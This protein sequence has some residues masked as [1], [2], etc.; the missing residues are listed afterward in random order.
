MVGQKL[1]PWYTDGVPSV[2]NHIVYSDCRPNQ[3]GLGKTCNM[4][5]VSNDTP[6]KL[7]VQT[8]KMYAPFGAK[9]WEAKEPNKLPKWDLVLNFKGNSIMMSTFT[10]LIKAIDESN[11]THAF[12][13]QESFFS[14]KGKS[15]DIIADRYSSLYNSKDSKYDP[16]LNTKLDVRN[17]QFNGQIYDANENIQTI[18]YVTAQSYVQALIEFGSLWVVD[19]R[20]GMTI[21]SIQL[22]VHKQDQIDKLSIVPMDTD[23][24]I[25][26]HFQNDQ[27]SEEEIDESE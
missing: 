1:V 27:L 23:E 4:N 26:T 10:D 2:M 20:F 13:N 6:A 22:M 5:Y 12:N 24:D 19:K 14:E 7:V 8:P 3:N 17:G 9:E 11:I 16:K 21:R 25:K 18:E 15:R